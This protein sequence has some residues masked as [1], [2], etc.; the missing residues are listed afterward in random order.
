MQ[1][2]KVSILN[3][4]NTALFRIRQPPRTLPSPGTTGLVQLKINYLGIHLQM[5][6]HN[7]PEN[8]STQ[9]HFFAYAHISQPLSQLHV[10]PYELV[11]YTQPRIPLNFPFFF[12]K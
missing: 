7:N 10:S 12:A 11:F 1:E 4:Q 3:L 2:L 5:F 6:L 9:L 8:W